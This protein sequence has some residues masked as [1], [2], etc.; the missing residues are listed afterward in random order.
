MHFAQVAEASPTGFDR[1]GTGIKIR[2]AT[3][4]LHGIWSAV[5]IG[6][7]PVSHVT[8]TGRTRSHVTKTDAREE[9]C[10]Q[11]EVR[12]TLRTEEE[13]SVC[14]TAFC[15]GS[16]FVDYE[17]CNL[18]AAPKIVRASTKKPKAGPFA[19]SIKVFT[20]PLLLGTIS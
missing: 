20:M 11:A 2:L 4:E 12:G 10:L 17:F 5:V 7:I 18:I 15:P 3:E 19:R 8:G 6:I 9:S 13:V 16:L 1:Q 14:V